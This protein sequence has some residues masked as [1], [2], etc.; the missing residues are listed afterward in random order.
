MSAPNQLAQF[1]SLKGKRVFVTGGGTGIGAAVVSALAEQGALV[2]FV[3]IAT[4][5]SEAL[6]QRI[7]ASGHPA[8]LFR[9][10]DLRDIP[11][12]QSTIADLASQLGD[13]DVLVNNAAN[14]ERHKLEDVTQEYWDNR[15][16]IN[17][18]PSFFAVQS[19]VPGMKKKGGGSIINFSSISWHTSGGGYPVYTTAKASVLGLTRGLAR[20]LGPHNIRVN[21]V[22][23]GWVMTERQ[24]ALWLDEKGKEDIKRNQ[25]LQGELLPWHLARM[26]LFLAADDSVMCTAQEFIVDAGWA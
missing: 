22:T 14:D 19:V 21:T 18:R 23:P 10:V 15:I 25:C 6:C 1:P 13:F 3:D 12:L 8:P 7:A 4:E 11:T 26:V 20:D 2:A 9:Q 5:A 24:I 16:A 17:Q